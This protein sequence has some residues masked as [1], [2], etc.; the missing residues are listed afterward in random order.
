MS[1]PW[2]R[3][4]AWA[5][6]PPR[7][8]WIRVGVSVVGVLVAYYAVPVEL[9][10]G[11][12][13]GP[14]AVTV[15]GVAVI[16]WVLVGQV[17]RSLLEQEV[18]LPFLV[19]MVMLVVAVFAFGY[20][21]LET[22]RPGEMVQLETRTDAL[23][24]TLQVMTTVGLGDVHAAGQTARALVSMQMAFDI[25]F[26][27]AG[28]SVLVGAVREQMTGARRTGASADHGDGG[29]ARMTGKQATTAAEQEDS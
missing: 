5:R 3:F 14:A 25:V 9:S 27:A 1:G 10:G 23:Y 13:I 15:L 6:R 11:R 19:T 18:R 22:V 2:Q 8:P 24:F 16:A 26:V 7:H 28:G 4:R 17:R 29:G 20:Y 21:A 12:A